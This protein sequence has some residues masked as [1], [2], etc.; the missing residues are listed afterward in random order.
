M[1]EGIWRDRDALGPPLGAQ[2]TELIETVLACERT[3]RAEDRVG[4]AIKY[5]KTSRSEDTT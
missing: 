1:K 2:L 3:W 4:A 5:E